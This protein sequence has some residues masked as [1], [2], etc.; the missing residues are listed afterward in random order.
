MTKAGWLCCGP[1]EKDIIFCF[2][3][4]STKFCI[5]N[6]HR[7]LCEFAVSIR[8]FGQLKNFPETE[9]LPLLLQ[10]KPN[11]L[12]N[13]TKIPFLLSAAV[14]AILSEY[15]QPELTRK[16]GKLRLPQLIITGFVCPLPHLLRATYFN[17]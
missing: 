17:Y 16:A 5:L 6:S 8:H 2:V 10:P 15:P 14:T 7:Y 3:S 4:H 13:I 1:C 12:I 9:S 11:W